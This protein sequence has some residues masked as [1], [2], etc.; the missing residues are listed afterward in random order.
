VAT[1][2]R[3]GW[4]GESVERHEDDG[5]LTGV[6]PFVADVQL[7][8]QLVA[9]IVRSP[10]AHGT[11]RSIDVATARA[12][13]GVVAVFTA[14]DIARDLGSVPVIYPRLSVEPSLEPYL[15]PVL[16]HD[17]VR[18]AGEAVA[19]VI[20]ETRYEAEDAGELVA[21][22]IEPIQPVLDSL[23]AND[24]P[25]LFEGLPN[26]IEVLASY[27]DAIAAVRDAEV[28]VSARIAIGRH[29]GVAMETRGL[30]ADWNATQGRMTL[31]G[32]TKVPHFK[33]GQLASGLGLAEDDV[34]I[35]SLSAG[36]GF[37]VKGEVYPE[38]FLIP[39]AAKQLGRPVS[40]IEDRHENL[41]AA[42]HSR[43]Q[44]HDATIAASADGR[45]L[46]LVTRFAHDGGAYLRTVGTR[47]AELTMGG[48]PGPYD[49]PNYSATG[50][51]ALTNKTPTG[52]YRSPGGFE[53]TFVCDRMIDLLAARIGKDPIEVRRQNLI[54]PEQMPYT[55]PLQSV[56][57]RIVLEGGDYVS[58][59]D[60]VVEAADRDQ[61]ARRRGAG[62]H[63]GIGVG[64]YL[65]KT[66]I[67]PWESASVC[68]SGELPVVVRTGATSLGQGI[69]TVLSQ[70]VA[71]E[72]GVPSLDVTVET[73]DTAK[74]GTGQGTYASRSTVMAGNAARLA[75]LAA[76]E[77]GR[78]FAAGALG[79]QPD[80]LVFQR[81][82]F[83]A[84]DPG[85]AIS[86]MHVAALARG[87]NGIGLLGSEVF[88]TDRAN[89]S[90]GT[91]AAI[92]SVDPELGAV[93]VER[94]VLGY[95]V[96]RAVNPRLVE[97]QLQGAAIQ[98]LGGALLEQF[99]YD[100]D[101]N[102]IATTF[103]DYLL[104]GVGDAPE[105]TVL[106][107]ESRSTLNP[108]GVKGAG[109]GG[110]CSVAAAIAG[111]IDDALGL[112]GAIRQ[113]PVTPEVV[114][115]AAAGRVQKPTDACG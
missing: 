95:D 92:V 34:Q 71:E 64:S 40:W 32:S 93:R 7:D 5:L 23:A 62:E 15:Q 80:A 30:V 11:L 56:D 19:V 83:E 48:I 73:G 106:L 84:E 47:V 44:I 46:A 14:E 55:R 27:G 36:G 79:V 59:F 77:R 39:W 16:A 105:L 91:V 100:K 70:I 58:E 104:P 63:V 35:L 25:P 69:R 49:I 88:R 42:N 110:I 101:G 38:D 98:A 90:H 99:T 6:E 3:T 26:C 60:R 1:S 87:E 81:G 102:P 109:E 9:T 112:P 94:L 67:G 4:I 76:I 108:L 29:T 82:S 31:H 114:W 53:A 115:R 97:G 20:A 28:I 37:G 51:Y 86:L 54:R 113:T 103:F 65:E 50:S 45:I 89:F 74:L 21:P 33:R 43:E 10:V 78:P 22:E 52:T 13:P 68:V 57:D 96:G 66:G 12:H 75:A 85:A 8:G 107:T 24:G 61:V 2:R 72:L 41:I 17:R 18:F 111:A